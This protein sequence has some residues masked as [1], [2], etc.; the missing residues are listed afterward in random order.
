ME[1]DS[2]RMDKMNV[3]GRQLKE[4]AIAREESVD[5]LEGVERAHS[6]V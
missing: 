4:P 6:P 2:L 5:E 1:I 3:H